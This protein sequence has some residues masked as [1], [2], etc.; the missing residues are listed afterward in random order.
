MP[1]RLLFEALVTAD[2]TI[3]VAGLYEVASRLGMTDQQVRLGIRRAVAAGQLEQSG[4]GKQA[5]LRV[6]A[7]WQATLLPDVEFLRH[8]YAQD[9]GSAPWDGRWHVMAFNIAESNRRARDA[10]RSGILRL[11][12]A[13]LQG[14]V[15]VSP[16]PWQ[17]YV[18][19]MVEKLGAL[20]DTTMLSCADLRVGGLT[21]PTQIAARLWCLPDIAA[22]Y[23][24]FLD[25]AADLSAPSAPASESRIDHTASALQLAH[26]FTLA[27]EPDPLLPAELLPQPWV[28]TTARRVFAEIW[29]QLRAAADPDAPQLFTFF[30]EVLPTGGLR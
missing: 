12:G 8:A 27:I 21:E 11:G 19:A 24:R 2:A 20:G 4:R 9:A 28:G 23:Q 29:T 17:P 3:D 6:T 30:S 15:Y 26:A 16:N 1:T 10:M 25:T 18:D 7:D 13:P 5:S 14:G 22:A